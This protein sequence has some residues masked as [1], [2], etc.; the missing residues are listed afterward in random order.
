MKNLADSS[1][2][3]VLKPSVRVGSF[4]ATPE[5]GEK[6]IQSDLAKKEIQRRV[7]TCFA[8]FDTPSSYLGIILLCAR[9]IFC[10]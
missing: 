3:D 1:P 5:K 2:D 7:T 8:S 6:Q 10:T 9:H 4:P